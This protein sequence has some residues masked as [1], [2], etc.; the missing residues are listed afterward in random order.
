MR[1][2]PATLAKYIIKML[3]QNRSSFEKKNHQT[4]FK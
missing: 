1:C 3:H 2:R 4:N